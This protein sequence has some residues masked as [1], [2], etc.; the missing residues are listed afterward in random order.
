MKAIAPPWRA[1][2]PAALLAL[3]MNAIASPQYASEETRRVIENL[4]QAHGGLEAWR[5]APTVGKTAKDY[6]VLYIDPETWRLF[7]Y[8]YGI[9]YQ[10]FLDLVNMPAGQ[11]TFGPLWRLI[12]KTTEV[13]GL[14]FPSA[15]RTMP[16]ADERIVGNH[17]ILNIDVGTPFEE[18]RAR[19]P[20]NAKV[21]TRK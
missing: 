3:S 4:V 14:V 11:E 16:E 18:A 19:V 15:F 12:T 13:G 1:L 10:P 6:F 9:G 7:G 5:A 17:V 21:D 8:Q 20:D 2:L